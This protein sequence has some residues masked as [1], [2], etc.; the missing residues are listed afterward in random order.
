MAAP[1]SKAKAGSRWGNL[2]SGAVAGIE[3]RLD[4][5]LAEDDQASAKS[6]A[7]ESAAKP[8]VPENTATERRLQVEQGER[9][10]SGWQAAGRRLTWGTGQ[11]RNSSRSRPSS[12][13]QDRLA[14]AV[15]KANDR[16]RSNSGASSDVPSGAPSPAPGSSVTFVETARASLDSKQSEAA[17]AEEEGQEDAGAEES[18]GGSQFVAADVMS[19]IDPLPS[20]ATPDISTPQPASNRQSI[21]SAR[22]RQSLELS[23]SAGV[24][25]DSVGIKHPAALESELASLQA[26]HQETLQEHR[27]ELNSHLERIDALQSKL[28]FLSEQLASEARIVVASEDVDPIEKKVAEKDAQIAALML[29]GQNLA[30]TELKHSTQIKKLRETARKT[31]KRIATLKKHLATAERGMDE[32]ADRARRAEYAERAAQERLKVVG[33]IEKDLHVIQAEREEAS[34]T[35]TELRRQL[36][37]ALTKVEEVERRV[38]ADALEAERKATAELRDDIQNLRIEKQLVEER[39]KKGIQEAKDEAAR[40]QERA[41]VSERELQSEIA[42]S[43]SWCATRPRPIILE[44]RNK[45]RASPLSIRGSDLFGHGRLADQTPPPGGNTADAVRACVRELAGH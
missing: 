18:S 14:K 24:G 28:G 39:G 27:E 45:T 22:S 7:A 15:N 38:Q 26:S 36:S 20:L 35:I 12:R 8:E 44:S 41:K 3:S 19:P 25:F 11:P 30:K 31:D 23:P 1:A 42:V 29:E 16:P 40:Q 33:R 34:L 9:L 4:T 10:L 5:I 43:T 21:D 13:L 17:L 6:R 32:A 37:E 2:L